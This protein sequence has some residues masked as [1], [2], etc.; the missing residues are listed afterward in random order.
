MLLEGVMERL[1]ILAVPEMFA[2]VAMIL[3]FPEMMMEPS[4]ILLE[5]DMERLAILAVPEIFAFPVNKFPF[6]F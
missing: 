2:V 1:A 5:G 3:P 6:V 4:V